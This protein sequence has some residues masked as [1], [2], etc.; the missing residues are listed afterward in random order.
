MAESVAGSTEIAVTLAERGLKVARWERDQVW[1]M[2]CLSALGRVHLLNEDHSRALDAL[3]E[4]RAIEL[5]MGIADPAMGF[6]HADLVEALATTG[7][8]NEA[9]RVTE[10]ITASAQALGRQC[11]L[12]CLQRAAGIQHMAAGEFAEAASALRA[13]T[14][15]LER[16]GLPLE[17]IRALLALAD[18]ERRRRRQAAA[19]D[20]LSAAH[21]LCLETGATAWLP[22][23]E[24]RILRSG[25]VVPGQAANLAPSELRVAELAGSGATNREIAASLYLSVKTVEA[26][27]SRIY[28]KLEVRSRTE[29]AKTMADWQP[30]GR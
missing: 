20:A 4:A 30:A 7:Q 27:L 12:A 9:R 15:Q 19:R 11:V 23:I 21:Q 29:L 25:A 18:V 1:A 5:T 2:K 17:R 24:Q 8:M 10:A 28:R 6:F 26:T 3:A 22:R 16:A 13:S 14:A